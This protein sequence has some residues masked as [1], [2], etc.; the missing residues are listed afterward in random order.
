MCRRCIFRWSHAEFLSQDINAISFI[1]HIDSRWR[2]YF[3]IM[4]FYIIERADFPINRQGRIAFS[5]SLCDSALPLP[6]SPMWIIAFHWRYFSFLFSFEPSLIRPIIC[7]YIIIETISSSRI[8]RNTRF[9]WFLGI[10]SSRPRRI[11]SHTKSSAP[12]QMS[13]HE[14][15]HALQVLLPRAMQRA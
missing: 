13:S 6:L 11:S 7:I 3:A 2:K 8:E 15:E 14:P 10:I 12:L 1:L 4:S 9:S 5:F